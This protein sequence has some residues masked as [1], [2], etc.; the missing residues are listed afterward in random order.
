MP[1]FK[2]IHHH[3]QPELGEHSFEVNPKGRITF[4]FPEV[5][6]LGRGS[7]LSHNGLSSSKWLFGGSGNC[8]GPK[9][10]LPSLMGRSPQDPIVTATQ[11]LVSVGPQSVREIGKCNFWAHSFL[12]PH[13]LSP[14]KGALGKQ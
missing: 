7:G 3:K 4:P 1:L 11:P 10:F 12:E 5:I 6:A 9:P 13:I 14:G 8:P 2:T